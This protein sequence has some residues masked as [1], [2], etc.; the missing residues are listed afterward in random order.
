L[1]I[2]ITQSFKSF[3][4]RPLCRDFFCNSVKYPD[5]LSVMLL[6]PLNLKTM[7]TLITACLLFVVIYAN[8]QQNDDVLHGKH[9][10][11][12]YAPLREADVMWAK[13]IWRVIDLNEKI[14]S[15]LRFPLSHSSS[16]RKSL[17]DI[18]MDAV[19]GGE[20]TAYS[21]LDDAFTLPMDAIEYNHIGGAGTDTIDVPDP[22]PPYTDII[23]KPIT[24]TFQ[25]DKVVAYRIKED[26]IFDKQRSVME[27]RI[28]GIAPMM[29]AEN[30]KGEKREDNI[31]VPL[32]WVYYPEVR[33]ILANSL[34]IYNQS[35]N[36]A[37][38]SF[39]DI[40]QKRMFGSYITKE[41]NVYDRTVAAYTSGLAS[42]LESDRIKQDV[43]DLEHDMWEY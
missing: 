38:P 22:N 12:D 6:Q 15:P 27:A 36:A 20:L 9:H 33:S 28:I 14:N 30:E 40:F 10:P 34:T 5:L 39:D 23:R 7:K 18:L 35:N 4:S 41:S 17:I 16:E 31:L 19:G 3:E 13:R 11:I 1:G 24:R 25:R 21:P 37:A 43:V 26:W 29:Y 8:G 2:L 42:A 32:F